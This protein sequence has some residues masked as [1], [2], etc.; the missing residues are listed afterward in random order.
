PR[1]ELHGLDDLRVGRAAAQVARKIVPDA[2]VVGLGVLLEQLARHQDE[3]R[4]AEAAL[5]A[6]A[7][8]ER[9][10]HR[11]EPA[12][13]LDGRHFAAFGERREIQAAGHGAAVDEHRAAATEALPAAFAR[14]EEA[15]C[16][17]QD[18]DQRIVRRHLRRHRLAVQAKL[19]AAPHFAFC[20]SM[21][22]DSGLSG[23]T[24]SLT[25]TASWSALAMAGDTPKVPVSP[26]PLAPKG[27]ER[28]SALTASLMI[29]SGMSR[30]P[31]ILYSAS[32]ALRSWPCSSNSIFSNSVK[33]SC[34]I[35]APESCLSTILGVI[36]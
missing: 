21:K 25:P 11:V 13:I 8:D 17:L 26:T 2:V 9:S 30:K 34:M 1:R 22:M 5:Q 36:A 24:A 31:G 19:N 29:S 3:P 10:L 14:A 33:Q 15:E 6:A 12:A 35:A 32:D 4:R 28:C 7:F 18:F 16:V 27:P 20:S 23:S